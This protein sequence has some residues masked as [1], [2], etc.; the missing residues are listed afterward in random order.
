VEADV[1]D[2][3]RVWPAGQEK[4]LG[5]Q[6]GGLPEQSGKEKATVANSSLGH[7]YRDDRTR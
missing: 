4:A 5:G 2:L 6:T 3:A 1:S 7:D